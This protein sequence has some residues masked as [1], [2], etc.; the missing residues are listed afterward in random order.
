MLEGSRRAVAALV[1]V[2]VWMFGLDAPWAQAQS[3]AT[4]PWL[5][6]LT[7][8]ALEEEGPQALH[9]ARVFIQ[10]QGGTVGVMSPAG[11]LLGWIP[12]EILGALEGQAGI[13]SVRTRPTSLTDL[14]FAAE[15]TGG[16]A[17]YF[18][19]FFNAVK[20]GAYAD[21]I[22]RAGALDW[23]PQGSDALPPEPVDQEAFLENLQRQGYSRELLGSL[24]M[25]D[26]SKSE[27]NDTMA[28]T[29]TVSLLICESDGSGPNGNLNDWTPEETQIV[30]D[31]RIDGLLW[32]SSVAPSYGCWAAFLV[33]VYPPTDPRCQHPYDPVQSGHVADIVDIVMDNFGYTG[34]HY[35]A[36]TAFNTAQRLANGTDRSFSIYTTYGSGRAFAYRWGPYTWVPWPPD[37]AAT[38]AHEVGHIFGACDEYAEACVTCPSTCSAN[39]VGNPNCEL[40][41]GAV[42]C[43][44]RNSTFTLCI[45]TDD[46]IGWSFTPCAPPGLP[47]PTISDISP[48]SGEAGT[49]IEATITG[50]NLLQAAQLDLGP[51]ITVNEINSSYAGGTTFSAT[52]IIDTQATPGTRDVT[53]TNPDLKFAAIP[54]AFEVVST[55]AHYYAPGGG[56][57]FPYTNPTDAATSLED[58]LAAAGPGDTIYMEAS[59]VVVLDE[60]LSVPVNFSGGWDASFSSQDLGNK[61]VLDLGV[62]IRSTADLGF[63]NIRFINGNGRLEV[64][65]VEG[66]YGGALQILDADLSL[67][68]CEFVGNDAFASGKVG[69]GG[70]VYQINGMLTVTNTA[71]EGNAAYVGGALYLDGVSGSISAST[72]TANWV[73]PGG[74]GL[75]QGAGIYMLGCTDLVLQDD[76]FDANTGAT[77]GGGLFVDGGTGLQV[78]GGSFLDHSVSGHGGGLY[79]EDAEILVDGVLFSGNAA[80]NL[81]GGFSLS[82]SPVA[83]VSASTFLQNSAQVG[84]GFDMSVG[85][86]DVLHN[87]F[88]GNT[89]AI[90][91]AACF[92]SASLGGSVVGNTLDGGSTAGADLMLANSPADA[93]NNIVVNSSNVAVYGSAATLDYNNVYN[94]GGTAYGGG[95]PGPGSISADPL[96]VDPV[97]NDYHLGLHSPCIDA[98]DPQASLADPDGGRGDMGW[99]GSHVFAMDQPVFP[100]S[101]AGEVVS[102][103]V[104]LS[105]D[106]NPEADLA[107]YAVYA[108]PNSGFTP[109][110]ATFVTQVPAGATT[111]DLGPIGETTHY[112]VS[113]VDAD[114]YAGGY[115]PQVTVEAGT[116]VD[117][118]SAYRFALHAA[119]PNPFNPQTTIRYDL[120]L[121]TAVLLTVFDVTGRRVKTLV[122]GVED[123]GSHFAVWDGTTDGG[124]RVASGVYYYKLVAGS[125]VATN[126]MVLLK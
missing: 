71:F 93:R 2:A 21:R 105:W 106:A 111:V 37:G 12:P 25:L 7:L 41:P 38:T 33:Y 115:S 56:D 29:V 51:G 117:T 16:Q 113:A 125:F 104:V 9:R 31:G 54:S 30:V 97:G 53:V 99:Y 18:V 98:G 20:T 13:R 80:T 114:G 45:A 102:G 116:P 96:F 57:N 70:A 84:G 74:V 4:R 107:Y 109:S 69:Y 94:P 110:L 73:D 48:V 101:V 44:M 59:S 85:T 47:G 90:S 66:R 10:E 118:P 27:N 50:T 88:V 124:A 35:N 86:C 6:D 121:R 28:G 8:V 120:E 112:R 58:A 119:V 67:D 1:L 5:S 62:N 123:P 108:S 126:R 32:W 42:Y 78:R 55:P 24:G 91:G 100:Q 103:D 23:R 34:N 26:L 77:S 83:T 11:V 81:G 36:S 64:L 3:H 65:P 92:V 79:V 40:C 17:D 52:V 75:L 63:D 49:T 22:R 122:S 46:H 15:K 39:G 89:A 43:I 14:G 95:T 72:F 87:L 61:T 60:R 19:G 82:N 68:H 76:V